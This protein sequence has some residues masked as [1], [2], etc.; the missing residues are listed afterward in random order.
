MKCRV[1]RETKD[2]KSITMKNGSPA[3]QGIC[4]TRGTKYSEPTGI[5]HA[6][7]HPKELRRAGFSRCRDIQPL[8]FINHT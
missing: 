5:R 1:K 4:P 3:T 8:Y 7:A 2:T 6:S